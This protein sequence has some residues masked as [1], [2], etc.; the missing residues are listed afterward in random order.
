M[1]LH[2]GVVQIV[3]RLSLAAAPERDTGH[4]GQPGHPIKLRFRARAT[5]SV[6]L[7]PPSLERMLLTWNLTVVGLTTNYPAISLLL[8]PF[9]GKSQG[10]AISGPAGNSL[11]VPAELPLAPGRIRL[12]EQRSRASRSSDARTAV[13]AFSLEAP[14]GRILGASSAKQVLPAEAAP[15]SRGSACGGE[16][17]HQGQYLALGEVVAGSL[18]RTDRLDRHPGRL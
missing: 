10:A 9:T 18:G 17:H 12:G 14:P 11:A 6:R 13:P 2:S 7:F 4:G 8:D 3:G 16:L 15:T 5:A 1:G